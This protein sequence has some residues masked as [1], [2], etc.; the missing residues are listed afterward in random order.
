MTVQE[1]IDE[2]N[3]VEDKSREVYY[4]EKYDDIEYSVNNVIDDG[5]QINLD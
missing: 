3:K 1:L 4:V 5:L 2:L